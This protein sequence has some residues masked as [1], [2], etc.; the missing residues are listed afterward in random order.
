MLNIK[1]FLKKVGIFTITLL[2]IFLPTLS[3]HN[4]IKINKTSSDIAKCYSIKLASSETPS[5]GLL[6]E[7]WESDLINQILPNA[8]NKLLL[9][10]IF[11]EM[12]SKGRISEEIALYIY[13]DTSL[14]TL[15]SVGAAWYENGDEIQKNTIS[16]R[17]SLNKSSFI[18]NGNFKDSLSRIK[19][20]NTILHELMHAFTYDLLPNGMLGANEDGVK[21]ETTHAF[22]LW[23]V[24]GLAQT[25]SGGMDDN[26][27]WVNSGLQIKSTSTT[28]TISSAI[29]TSSNKLNAGTSASAYG[30]GY[31]ACTY[32]GYLASNKPTS[33]TPLTIRNGISAM[34]ENII[35]GCSLDTVIKLISKNTYT[36]LQDFENNFATNSEALTF[37]KT[38]LTN[39]GE[40]ISSF[41]QSKPGGNGSIL[42]DSFTEY[43]LLG[44]T[45]STSLYYN[46]TDEST[47]SASN[48][49]TTSS[50][51]DNRKWDTG[52]KTVNSSNFSKNASGDCEYLG[53]EHLYSG[54]CD[55]TCNN[56]GCTAT[57]TPTTDHT[58][59]LTGVKVPTHTQTGYTG[60]TVCDICGHLIEKGE[61]IP[62]LEG[63]PPI[64]D[65]PTTPPQTDP[66][67]QDGETGG[68]TATN[69]PKPADTNSK[70]WVIGIFAVL[71]IIALLKNKRTDDDE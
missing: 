55:E 29:S 30:T 66:P 52:T 28:T 42:A 33:I 62:M 54:D 3:N 1:N 36:S 34:L 39:T 44:N 18:S 2:L 27:D 65:T 64:D 25:C 24:E 22:P 7:S 38:L 59:T 41:F 63:E 4:L 19:L 21:D 37:I 69:P 45:N 32:L 23:F 26:N 68:G 57:K 50:A 9:I 20:E 15:A 14:A 60:D 10:P 8:V 12:A 43:D 53:R 51:N 11:S 46:L 5:I 61:D 17:L 67:I 40:G 71:I 31:L 56:K 49:Y 13:S 6:G 58:P 35:N 47:S 70:K 16:F 48:W